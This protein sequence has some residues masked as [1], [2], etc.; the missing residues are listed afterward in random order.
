MFPPVGERE[1]SC[2]TWTAPGSSSV[3]TVSPPPSPVLLVSGLVLSSSPDSSLT[4]TEELY[5]FNPE[6]SACDWP[7]AVPCRQDQTP[8]SGAKMV[9]Q[10]EDTLIR[11]NQPRNILGLISSRDKLSSLTGVEEKVKPVGQTNRIENIDEVLERVKGKLL[12]YLQEDGHI[13]RLNKHIPAKA[14]LV[15]NIRVKTDVRES[16]L[17]R[18]AVLV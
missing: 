3:T 8:V 11:H 13:I 9:W 12:P 16:F 2:L 4:M 18:G 17:P 5:R 6:I 7:D 15:Q 10:R 1:T 14:R